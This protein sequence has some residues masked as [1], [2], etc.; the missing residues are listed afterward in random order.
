MRCM[1]TDIGER[2]MNG[3]LLDGLFDPDVRA[4]ISERSR[5]IARIS[6]QAGISRREAAD[7]LYSFE[8]VTTSEGQTLH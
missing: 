7:A 5:I 3:G 1:A 2:R 6:E 4:E 8:F